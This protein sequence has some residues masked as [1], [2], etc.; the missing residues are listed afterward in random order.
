M[1]CVLASINSCAGATGVVSFDSCI[2]F[3]IASINH[4]QTSHLIAHEENVAPT[5]NARTDMRNANLMHT[6]AISVRN[7][8]ATNLTLI[9]LSSVHQNPLMGALGHLLLRATHIVD[10]VFMFIVDTSHATPER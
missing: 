1:K 4:S 9:A 3:V 6:M 8:A 2:A 7:L 5:F 10:Q